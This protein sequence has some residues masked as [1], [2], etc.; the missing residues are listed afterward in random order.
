VK[1]GMK[2]QPNIGNVD[3]IIRGTLG[4]VLIVIAFLLLDAADAK[5]GGIVLAVFGVLLILTAATRYCVG[6]TLFHYSTLK[7]I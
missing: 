4:I 5:V 2:I 6:Y 1:T 7:N 3:R